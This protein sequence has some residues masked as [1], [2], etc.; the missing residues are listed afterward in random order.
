VSVEA[1]LLAILESSAAPELQAARM[2]YGYA[3]Q[4]DEKAPTQLPLL[5]LQRAGSQWLGT[6]AGRFPTCVW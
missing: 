3:A 5:V 6:L 2:S 1:R 4:D